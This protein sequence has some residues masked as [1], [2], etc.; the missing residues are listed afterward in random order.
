VSLGPLRLGR[1]V[2]TPGALDSVSQAEITE[3]LGRHQSGDWGEVEDDDWAAND[4]AVIEGS[5]VLSVYKVDGERI[6]VITE[7][8][9]S[10]TAVLLPSEY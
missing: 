7:A 9:R 10:S 3:L 1:V 2:V 4:R 8:D 5:R 6:W